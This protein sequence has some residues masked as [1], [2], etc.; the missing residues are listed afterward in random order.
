MAVQGTDRGAG[1]IPIPARIWG[2]AALAVGS[3]WACVLVASLL[4]PDMVTGTQHEHL[5]IVGGTD[6]IWGL[7]AM[8][9]VILAIQRGIRLQAFRLTSWVVLAVGVAISW[10][11]VVLVTAFAPAMVTGTDPTTLP[12]TAMGIPILGTFLTWFACT[13]ARSGFEQDAE[14]PS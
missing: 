4:A 1:R 5:A 10:M 9:F 2:M 11:P 13:L 6:W 12:L 14:T 7:V 8:A 3:I